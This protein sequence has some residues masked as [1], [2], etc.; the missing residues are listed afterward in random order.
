[1][2][3]GVFNRQIV[4]SQHG[5]HCHH[6]SPFLASFLQHGSCHMSSYCTWG[7]LQRA[8]LGLRLGLRILP[9][10]LEV[11]RRG[12][13][14]APARKLHLD[15]HELT[16]H[17]G[18]IQVRP[19]DGQDPCTTKPQ[20]VSERPKTHQVL[21][22]SSWD[23]EEFKCFATLL[24]TAFDPSATPR[25][26]AHHAQFLRHSASYT[27]PRLGLEPICDHGSAHALQCEHKHVHMWDLFWCTVTLAEGKNTIS[28]SHQVCGLPCICSRWREVPPLRLQDSRRTCRPETRV[29]KVKDTRWV[30]HQQTYASTRAHTQTHTRTHAC[31][32]FC[33]QW[34]I[35]LPTPWSHHS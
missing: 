28:L 20:N 10:R 35:P 11:L 1:M 23:N 7:T 33:T 26:P 24:L 5:W 22:I 18:Q 30:Q 13:G 2:L 4:P 31:T 34:L 8:G 19:A 29:W 3:T 9:R 12:G 25:A 15:E 21:K 16:A 6:T 14:G 17:L 27:S 32:D